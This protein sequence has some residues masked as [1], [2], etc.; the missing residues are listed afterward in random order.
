MNRYKFI[1]IYNKDIQ[2]DNQGN[3]INKKEVVCQSTSLEHARNNILNIDLNRDDI[4][5]IQ[6]VSKEKIEDDLYVM[7]TE[8]SDGNMRLSEVLIL[9]NMERLSK[10]YTNKNCKFFKLVPIESE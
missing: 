7:A 1:V 5:E 3:S 9:E 4:E 6:F 2:I 10:V 8:L